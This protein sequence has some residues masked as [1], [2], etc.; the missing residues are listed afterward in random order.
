MRF[1]RANKKVLS[2]VYDCSINKI[3]RSFIIS[4]NSLF[5][6]SHLQYFAGK[7]TGISRE[8]KYSTLFNCR[9][10][11]NYMEGRGFSTKNGRGEVC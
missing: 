10:R 8:I 3:T 4:K 11:L 7:P 6:T 1:L 5:K 9:E 2:R